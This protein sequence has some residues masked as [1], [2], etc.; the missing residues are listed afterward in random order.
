M[1]ILTLLAPLIS[2]LFR[3]IAVK[4]LILTALFILM[5]F[6]LPFL[7]GLLSPAISTSSLSSAFSGLDGGVSYWLSFFAIDAGLPLIISAAITRFLIRRL[8]F[9]G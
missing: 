9:I 5:E 1:S 2:F 8:P 3:G 7:L 4:F 6:L